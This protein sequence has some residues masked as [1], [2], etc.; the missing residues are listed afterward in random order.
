MVSTPALK[1]RLSPFHNLIG[2]IPNALDP[3]T[4]REKPATTNRK[5]RFGYLASA[6][7]GEYL[8]SIL[9]PLKT[10]LSYYKNWIDFEIIGQPGSSLPTGLFGSL[11]VE[12]I[13]PPDTSYK[14]YMQWLRDTC[15][16]DFGLAPI[17]ANDFTK[18][19]SDMKFLDFTRLGFPGIYTDFTPYDTVKKNKAGLITGKDWEATLSAMIENPAQRKTL[20]SNAMD[21]VTSERTTEIQV[22]QWKTILNQL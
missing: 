8:F 20:L 3:K 21:Y 13:V 4:I 11:P 1:E 19:K 17:L 10:V 12:Y 14:K 7:N 2:V 18:C 5:V 15:N 16:W 9:E 22:N 6:D